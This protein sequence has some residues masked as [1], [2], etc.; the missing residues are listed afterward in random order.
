[1]EDAVHKSYAGVALGLWAV[2]AVLTAFGYL[3][4]FLSA[5]DGDSCGPTPGLCDYDSFWA[6]CNTFYVGSLVL[7]GLSAVGLFVLHR[8][9]R[10]A[11]LPPVAGLGAVLLLLVA[12]YAAERAAVQLPFYG[13][14]V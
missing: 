3:N 2:Q 1:M 12:T 13:N 14:R 4:T 7:L 10:L 6:A 5:F 11:V 9:G 8:R